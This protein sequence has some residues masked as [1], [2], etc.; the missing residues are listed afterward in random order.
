VVILGGTAAI[1]STAEN[2]LKT[3]LGAANVQR[4]GGTNRYETARLVAAATV[5]FL[6]CNYKG[7]AFVT[8]GLNFPD[9]LAA[10]PL[11][12][13][14]GWP[15]YL[16]GPA[17]LDAPTAAAMTD[18][19][20]T[21]ALALGSTSAVPASV[22]TAIG[23]S[24]GATVT[25]LSGPDRYSTAV[26]VAGYGVANAG[27]SWDGITIATGENFPDG[28]SAGAAQGLNGSV[29]LLTRTASLP[30][31]T[32]SALTAH[33]DSIALLRFVGSDQAIS[34]AVRVSVANLLK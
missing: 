2:S 30:A 25:R 6:D 8:T 28:L 33:K 19:G 17:G 23:T 1:S 12:A 5:K 4:I 9:A 18:I 20:V 11:A 21:T 16:V 13:A 26:A 34:P 15:I 31:P 22:A 27:L 29:L 3:L 14:K 10:G 7:S 24:V 32:A